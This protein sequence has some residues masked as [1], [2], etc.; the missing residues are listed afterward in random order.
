MKSRYLFMLLALAGCGHE[1]N[2]GD[3]VKKKGLTYGVTWTVKY[4]GVHN[5]LLEYNGEVESWPIDDL[6]QVEP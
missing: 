2:I 1:I 4:V 3:H 6:S 5:A